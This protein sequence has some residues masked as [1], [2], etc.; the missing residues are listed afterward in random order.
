MA[1]NFGLIT[2]SD[3]KGLTLEEA[4]LKAETDGFS[5][6]IVE[7][8][9]EAFILTM[10]MKSNRINFRVSGDIVIEAYTG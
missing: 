10:D 3:W 1:K 4:Q 5:Y 7:R 9:G 2:P 8:D 6:R